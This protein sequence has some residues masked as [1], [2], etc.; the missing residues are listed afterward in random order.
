MQAVKKHVL[1]IIKSLPENVSIDTIMEKLYF[2]II[3]DKGLYGLDS[4]KGIPHSKV[5]ERF[6]TTS[7]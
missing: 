5:K 1:T 4:G 3:V 6:S 2:K 7:D